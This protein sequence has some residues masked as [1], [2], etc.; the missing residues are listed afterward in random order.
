[1]KIGKTYWVMGQ[2]RGRDKQ[3]ER[4]K[5]ERERSGIGGKRKWHG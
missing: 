3:R 5:K 4:I 2:A 1:M